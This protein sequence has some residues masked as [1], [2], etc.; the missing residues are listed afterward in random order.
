MSEM[1]AEDWIVKFY[2]VMEEGVV[3]ENKHKWHKNASTSL[4]MYRKMNK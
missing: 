3:L 4:W 1:S 2:S